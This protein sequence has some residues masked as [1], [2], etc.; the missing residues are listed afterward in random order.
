M[1][2][3]ELCK[4]LTLVSK[5]DGFWLNFKTK[6]GKFNASINLKRIGVTGKALHTWAKETLEIE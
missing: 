4:G 3:R 6:D 1:I 5:K 2:S